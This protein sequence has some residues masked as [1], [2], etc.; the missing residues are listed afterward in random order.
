VPNTPCRLRRR[1]CLAGFTPPAN[2]PYFLRARARVGGSWDTGL[3]E[4]T[5][6]LFHRD[7]GLFRD[8]FE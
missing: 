6:R 5:A 4:T 7:D 3:I 1:G 8:G 2:Q